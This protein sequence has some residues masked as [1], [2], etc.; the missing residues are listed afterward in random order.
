M[1]WHNICFM[2]LGGTTFF[3]FAYIAFMLFPDIEMLKVF[4]LFQ[5]FLAIFMSVT[6]YYGI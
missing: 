2:M 4:V 5:L 6:Y 3:A 1:I